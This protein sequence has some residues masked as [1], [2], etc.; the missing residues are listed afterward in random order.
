MNHDKYPH[1]I[2]CVWLAADR[3]GSLAAFISAGI[4]PIPTVALE[5][6]SPQIEDMEGLIHQ[7]PCTSGARLLVSV[8]RPDSFREL[9]ERGLFVYDWQDVHRNLREEVGVYEL[10]A[11]PL[12]PLH[13]AA[14][15]ELL[16]GVAAALV[17]DG[18]AFAGQSRLDTRE[19]MTCV[20]GR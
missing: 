7:L 6:T 4:A 13:V 16:H 11:V 10:V 5:M 8:K 14:L 17:F 19:Q 18:L 3:D 20:A 1:Q 9:A 12:K 2:D 15:P